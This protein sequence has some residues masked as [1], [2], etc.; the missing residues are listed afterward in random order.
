MSS[1]A[2]RL[3]VVAQREVAADALIDTFADAVWLEDGLAPNTLTAYRR[4][5]TG[6]STWLGA[7]GVTLLTAREPELAQYFA[8]KH[9][10]TLASTSNR[11]LAVLRRF[12]RWAV[13]EGRLAQDPRCA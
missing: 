1:R 4:D 13:R 6:L 7:R 11:R 9:A 3:A 12:Y 5:L 10:T 2:S 8:D